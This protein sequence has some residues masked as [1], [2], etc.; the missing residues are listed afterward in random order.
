MKLLIE[1]T[2]DA[3]PYAKQQFLEKYQDKK[4][5]KRCDKDAKKFYDL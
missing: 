2:V 4:I 3:T 5:S 1:T